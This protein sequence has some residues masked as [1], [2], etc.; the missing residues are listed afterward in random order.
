MVPL[1]VHFGDETYR[2]GVDLN[3]DAVLRQARVVRGAPDHVA[4]HRRRVQRG[5]RR[6]P[7]AVRAR[8]LPAH[9]GGDERDRARR[10]AGGRG[11]RRSRGLRPAHRRDHAGS[12][13]R[14]SARA[15]RDRLHRWTRRATTSRTS[16][17]NSHLIIHAATLEYLRRGGRIG[18]AASLVGGV[19][20]IKPLICTSTAPSPGTPRSAASR[21]PW[22]PWSGSSRTTAAATTS[23][24]SRR[25]DAI[26]D[27]EPPLLPGDDRAPAAQ[28]ALRHARSRRRRRRHAH[29]PGD[30]RLRHDRGVTGSGLP[31]RFGG[32][33]YAERPPVPRLFFRPD[34]LSETALRARARDACRRAPA[35]RVRPR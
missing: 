13:L 5:L 28:R 8:L 19:F 15:P 29:R 25:L 14:A 32:G 17:R 12:L 11:L 9:L 18:R 30:V 16:P 1:K 24:T 6:G 2:D 21:R 22:P 34:T 31:L 4:A 20:D 35:D 3:H 23:C 27:E 7:R 10:G 26:N 33:R